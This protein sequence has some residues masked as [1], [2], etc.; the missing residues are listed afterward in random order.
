MRVRIFSALS[1]GPVA[2]GVELTVG[3]KKEREGERE[4][5]S[6]GEREGERK[7]D[8]LMLVHRHVASKIN[9]DEHRNGMPPS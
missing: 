7:R 5:E 1:S 4:R 2:K 3:E 9:R 6:G 8:V